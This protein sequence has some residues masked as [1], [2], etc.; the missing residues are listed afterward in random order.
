VG[1]NFNWPGYRIERRLVWGLVLVAVPVVLAGCAGWWPAAPSAVPPAA[2]A[3]PGW[4]QPLPGL[5]PAS[6]TPPAATR[7]WTALADPL[8]DD[9]VRQALASAPDGRTAQARLREVRARRDATAAAQAPDLSAGARASRSRSSGRTNSLFDLGF[10]ASWEADVFARQQAAVDAAEADTQASAASLQDVQLTLAAEVARLYASLRSLQQRQ[11]L[12]RGHVARQADTLQITRWRAQA[13]LV[14]QLDVVQAQASLAQTQAQLAGLASSLASSQLQLELLLGLPPS[15]LASRLGS[16]SDDT[17]NAPPPPR[18]PAG[19]SI[20]LP[21]EVLRQRADVRQAE[22]QWRAEAARTTQAHAAQFPRLTLSG[23][24]GLQALT[25]GSL[26]Q[27]GYGSLVAGLTAPLLDGG[28]L[29][30]QLAQQ[31]AVRDRAA[32]AYEQ[33]MLAALSEVEV[34]LAALDASRRQAAALAQ[35]AAAS[36]QAAE[37]ARLRYR[38]G[39]VDFRTVLDA[40]RTVLSAEDSLASARASALSAWIQLHKALGAG[41]A[42]ASDTAAAAGANPPSSG[43]RP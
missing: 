33:A 18:L 24:L 10:D 36:G 4:Q 25:L 2:P 11:A 39:L 20:T 29:R 16:A 28:Q 7:W 43:P 26:G 17:R 32:V 23:S 9:L 31:V 6:A 5:A 41:V 22:A 21:A 38:S 14:S 3:V 8:L 42:T 19:G 27:G 34:A 13:G 35:A 37:L 1:F 12:A 15:L 30:A 40:E